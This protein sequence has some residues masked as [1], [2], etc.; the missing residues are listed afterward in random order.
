MFRLGDSA[1]F[2]D[3]EKVPSIRIPNS[4]FQ[5]DDPAFSLKQKKKVIKHFKWLTAIACYNDL[6]WLIADSTNRAD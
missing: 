4:N 6:Q 3:T 1:A 2:Y 5:Q